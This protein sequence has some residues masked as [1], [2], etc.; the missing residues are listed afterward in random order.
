LAHILIVDDESNLRKVLAGILRT[1]GHEVAEATGVA[2]ARATLASQLFDLVITDQKMPDGDG[3]SLLA[4]CRESDPNLPVVLLTAFAT[5][6]LAVE[7][8]RQGAFDVIAKPFQPEQVAAVVSRAVEHTALRREN[9]L[10]R[11][12]AHAAKVELIGDS[13]PMRELRAMIA[14]VGPTAAT[15]LISGE[16]GTGK[17]MVAR[18][19]HE[20]SPRADRPFL[21]VNC[22]A[23]TETLLASELFGHERGAFTGADRTRQGVFEAAH[24]GTLFLDEAGEMTASLQAKLL[25]VLTDREIVRVGS[26]TPRRVDV[27]LLVATHRDL[28]H[29]VQEGR[30]R[31]DLYYRLAVVPIHVPPLRERRADIPVLAQHLADEVA[32][33]LKLPRRPI[34]AAALARLQRYDFPGNVRELRNLL[35]RASI[36]TAGDAIS[37]GDLLPA[38]RVAKAESAPLAAWVAELPGHLDLRAA[39]RE[40]ERALVARALEASDGVQAEAARRLGL[41]RS[42]LTYKLRR[43]AVGRPTGEDA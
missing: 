36:L 1:A 30:F 11:R 19:L 38:D 7:A 34:S 31:D 15:V 4:A 12:T 14:R 21:A 13:P 28:A 18:A 33:E 23:F 10:L 29:E 37:P 24:H 32:R 8:M 25:R 41:S 2:T 26:T 22:A 3:L 35:E 39:L 16:T 20:A 27:R 6:E 5:V 42:D 9:T 40:V 43:L 17:E